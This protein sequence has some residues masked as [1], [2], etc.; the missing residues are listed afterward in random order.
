MRFNLQHIYYARFMLAAMSSAAL[1]LMVTSWAVLL[2][3]VAAAPPVPFQARYMPL[4]GGDNLVRSLDGRS[5][6]LKL[7]AH[8]GSGF[9]SK[10]AYRHGFFSASIKLPDDYT[11]GVVVAFY[12]S[13]G[14]VFRRNHDEVDFELLGNRRGH[15]W[16][17]Q[18]NI[19]GNGSTSRGREERY[20]LPFDPT[21]RPHAYAVAWT[22]NAVIFYIDGT[23][24]REVVRVTA[25]GGDFPAKPMSVYAT[26]WDGSAWATDGGTYKVD[27]AYA[28]FAADFSSLVVLGCPAIDEEVGN[29]AASAECEVELMTAEC[30]VMT[31]G[32]RAAMRRFR[33]RYLL[34]TVCHDRFRYNGTIFPECDADGTDRDDFHAWGESKRVT[35]RRRGYKERAAVAGR[36]STWPVGALRAD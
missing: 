6:R 32:K 28:P 25:M 7:D 31:P 33:R 14:D 21:L 27:Y 34:Y 3:V 29:A 13:N 18:T 24:I 16:R 19:Y 1:V 11:A 20:L 17:V 2:A 35:P 26:I 36:P 12:L 30:P 10:S 23:P 5:V 8:T 22:A 4:F 9:V 15:E